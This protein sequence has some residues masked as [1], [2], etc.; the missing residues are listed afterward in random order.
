MSRLKNITGLAVVTLLA[1]G[2]GN[3]SAD[4][5]ITTLDIIGHID[6]ADTDNAEDIF[7]TV[8][9]FQPAITDSTLLDS[10]W[11]AGVDDNRVYLYENN[12]ENRMMVFDATD[13]KCISSFD[14][15]GQGPEE[16][17]SMWKAWK[18]VNADGWTVLDV[19]TKRL[20]VYSIDGKFE[21]SISNDSI[22]E[23][24]PCG[25]GWVALNSFLRSK[26]LKLY[27]YTADWTPVGTIDTG[28]EHYV[29]NNGSFSTPF[30]T[31][32]C[33]DRP[34]I[35]ADDTLYSVVGDRVEPA[36]ILNTGK[37]HMPRFATS[38]EKRVEREKY[39]NIFF[40][41]VNDRHAIVGFRYS[42]TAYYQVYRLADG[43][44]IFS[45]SFSTSHEGA[46]GFPLKVDGYEVIGIP[47]DYTGKDDFY[48]NIRSEEMGIVTGNDDCNPAIVKVRIKD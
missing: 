15:T 8:W 10:P 37:L 18:T 31:Y 20:L 34:Y 39:I 11:M 36:V 33:G 25:D 26:D 28:I 23:M 7:E 32:V 4:N 47:G 24:L 2:C 13:G 27:Q 9:S 14:N 40:S 29:L 35:C 45:K 43:E 1:A 22:D 38:Q 46:Y 41:H 6:V 12:K 5:D 19:R 30:R 17:T 21:R 48:F 3:K 44:M 42:D 16:Y